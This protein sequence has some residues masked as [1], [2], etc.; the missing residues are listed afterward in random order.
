MQS[1]EELFLTGERDIQISVINNLGVLLL[2]LSD[3]PC[4]CYI[5][6]HLDPI[7]SHGVH[8]LDDELVDYFISFLK[9]VT[10]LVTTHPDE[11][12]S[13]STHYPLLSM[14]LL[15]YRHPENMVR[16]TVRN[17]ILSLLQ[18]KQQSVISLFT[19]LPYSTFWNNL[20]LTLS[21]TWSQMDTL[22]ECYSPKE[23]SRL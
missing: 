2:N 7:I 11:Y 13:I 23:A 14:A 16:T 18:T 9:Q 6:R 17:I 15:F 3:R 1:I 4:L 8:L 21:S 19:C 10:Q 22:I 12:L 5:L 20:T